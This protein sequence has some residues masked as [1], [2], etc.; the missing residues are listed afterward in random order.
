M[1]AAVRG[2]HE[3]MQQVDALPFAACIVALVVVIIIMTVDIDRLQM[4]G[5]AVAGFVQVADCGED[6]IHQHRELQH[7][8]RGKAQQLEAS[9]AEAGHETGMVAEASVVKQSRSR[10]CRAGLPSFSI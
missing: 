6:R 4:F 1:A 5:A 3:R 7:R 2:M 8:Q 9:A 10:S